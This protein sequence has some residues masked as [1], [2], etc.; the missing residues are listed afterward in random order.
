MLIYY[1]NLIFTEKK[2]YLLYKCLRN[3][4][5]LSLLES[6]EALDT[7]DLLTV[8]EACYENEQKKIIPL[9]IYDIKKWI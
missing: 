5:R 8:W 3:N 1:E 4:K 2:A 6:K 9:P 7:E